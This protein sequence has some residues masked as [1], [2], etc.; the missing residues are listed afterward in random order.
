[1]FSIYTGSETNK[2]FNHLYEINNKDLLYLNQYNIPISNKYYITLVPNQ[3]EPWNSFF[4]Y[5]FDETREIE[6]P[7]L[8]NTNINTGLKWDQEQF[9]SIKL[10]E[11]NI[12]QLSNDLEQV[13]DAVSESD[14]QI[15]FI[16]DIDYLI[17]FLIKCE[18][19][20][21]PAHIFDFILLKLKKFNL[22]N[23]IIFDFDNKYSKTNLLYEQIKINFKITNFFDSEF[24]TDEITVYKKLIDNELN[25]YWNLINPLDQIELNEK[26]NTE[27]I[28]HDL[29]EIFHGKINNTETFIS[30]I[31]ISDVINKNIFE[32]E[33]NPGIILDPLDKIYYIK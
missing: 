27:T 29:I 24:I 25:I 4:S 33:N 19:N 31:K 3:N 12:T 13:Y 30:K 10:E 32:L 28:S 1:M 18:K 2:L 15:T 21:T 5:I 11:S 16:L 17:K 7:F 8:L 23:I 20:N 26:I 9:Y 6:C 22:E 14:G